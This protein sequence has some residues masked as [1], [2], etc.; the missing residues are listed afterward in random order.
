MAGR[1]AGRSPNIVAK[2]VDGEK[3]GEGGSYSGDSSHSCLQLLIAGNLCWVWA[4]SRRSGRAGRGGWLD[5]SLLQN[6]PGH[7]RA[8]RAQSILIKLQLGRT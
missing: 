1:L 5:P 3:G 2:K 8:L 4:P 6:T 7:A